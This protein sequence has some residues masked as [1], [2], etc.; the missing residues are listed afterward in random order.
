MNQRSGLKENR[1]QLPEN[2]FEPYEP[3][4]MLVNFTKKDEGP[5]E[6]VAN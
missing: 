4:R 5:A 6:N 3:Q 1:W 2:R